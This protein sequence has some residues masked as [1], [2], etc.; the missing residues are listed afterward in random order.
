MMDDWFVKCWPVAYAVPEE[1]ALQGNLIT[2]ISKVQAKKGPTA[3][4]QSIRVKKLSVES[5]AP[6]KRSS[7]AAGHD[8]SAN[9]GT[10]VPA[11]CYNCPFPQ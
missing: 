2:G 11:R 4:D 5:R 7:E 6:R 9:E 1:K 3:Y 8:L 10:E